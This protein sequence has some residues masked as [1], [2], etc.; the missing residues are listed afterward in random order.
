M[1]DAPLP[2]PRNLPSVPLLVI[3]Q[4]AVSAASLVVEI[5]AGRMLAPYVGM[6]LYTWTSIIAVVLAGF[7]AGHWAGGRIAE[8]QS[9]RALRWTGWGMIGAA[10]STAAALF[11]LRWGAAAVL[12]M[13]ENQIVAIVAL[14]SIAFFLPSFFAGVPA[15]VLAQIAVAANPGTS[16]RALGAMFAAGAIGAIAG[17]LLAGFVFISWLGSAGTLVAVTLSYLAAAALLLLWARRAGAAVAWL[18]TGLSF[19]A[20]L[21]LAGAALAQPSPCTRESDYFCIRTVDISA[22]PNSPV[23]MMVLDHLVHGRGARDLPDVMF[24]DSAAL[25]DLL[26]QARM[27]RRDFSAFFI[28]GG[29]FSVPRKWAQTTPP[30]AVTVAEIDPAVTEVAIRDFWFDPAR[31][32][33]LT[34]DARAALRNRPDRYDVIV[35]DAFTD[36][37]VPP[38]L[39]TREFFELV[40]DRLEPGGSYLMNVV[41]HADN[42]RALASM[43][44][45][46]QQVFP[47][48]EVW[49]E[50]RRPAPGERM[51]FILAAGR[52]ETPV[53]KLDGQSPAPIRFARL[54]DSTIG[55]ILTNRAPLVLT[56]DFAPIDRLMGTRF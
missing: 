11:L 3:V 47:V 18:W 41:D 7:S 29:T 22:D 14:C 56:D 25:F 4:A 12:P 48:V 15:P 1:T 40:R 55:A 38:H 39:I 9:A 53:V 8:M 21:A 26:A 10:L 49:S 54:A 30:A 20:G 46:L 33:V 51:V 35:G 37:A 28:G 36:I 50:A 52:S 27:G 6:S 44:V 32:T 5:V 24:Y 43:V 45:T 13:T 31:A 23:H 19:L 34:E 16:G 2:A 17:T 42:L